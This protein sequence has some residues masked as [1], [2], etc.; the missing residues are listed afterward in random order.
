M[1]N[2]GIYYFH[3]ISPGMKAKSVYFFLGVFWILPAR[4]VLTLREL[5]LLT[6]Q[7]TSWQIEWTENVGL[8]CKHFSLRHSLTH[9]S[10]VRVVIDFHLELSLAHV[11]HNHKSKRD[12]VAYISQ[13]GYCRT[14]A[15]FFF[16]ISAQLK[17]ERLCCYI[18]NIYG[19]A[20]PE[21]LMKKS[22]ICGS[23]KSGLSFFY[24]ILL[25]KMRDFV[26]SP[27]NAESLWKKPPE[28]SRLCWHKI[29]LLYK[30]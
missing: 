22:I 12:C 20:Q 29:N 27:T 11:L 2:A 18:A 9:S 16:F 26:Q 14:A 13:D 19:L 10:D 28:I 1:F 3:Y 24:K 30:S 4:M 21:V 8:F 23:T 17:H 15:V 7:S 25:A 6:E 5:F